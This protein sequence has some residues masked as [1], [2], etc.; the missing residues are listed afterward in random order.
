MRTTPRFAVVLAAAA[1][2]GAGLGACGDDKR[3]SNEGVKEN[4]V[5][6]AT[7]QTN[8]NELTST[9]ETEPDVTQPGGSVTETTETEK[10]TGT[11]EP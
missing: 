5:E 1:L 9:G 3:E 4:Q 10:T 7:V 6:G 2:A 8:P 11:D